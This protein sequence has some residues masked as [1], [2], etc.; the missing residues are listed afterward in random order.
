M[1]TAL[2]PRAWALTVYSPKRRSGAGTAEEGAVVDALWTYSMPG[3]IW[4]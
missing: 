3:E 1:L 2:P 4:T